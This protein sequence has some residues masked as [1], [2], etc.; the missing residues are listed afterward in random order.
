MRPSNLMSSREAERKETTITH[1]SSSSG[2]RLAQKRQCTALR[3]RLNSS[4]CSTNSRAWASKPATSAMP[5]ALKYSFRYPDRCRF[6]DSRRHR[7]V[8]FKANVNPHKSVEKTMSDDHASIIYC[9]YTYVYLII[10]SF[11][12]PHAKRPSMFRLSLSRPAKRAE[13]VQ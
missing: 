7:P 12:G 10:N 11:L 9:F 8:F 5:A 2:W 6:S 4:P 1:L 3:T 13:A